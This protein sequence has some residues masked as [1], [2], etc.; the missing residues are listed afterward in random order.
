M[1]V[2][3]VK[4]RGI[5]RSMNTEQNAIDASKDAVESSKV[6]AEKIET[7]RLAQVDLNQDK[8]KE[9]M[10]EVLHDVFDEKVSSGRFID[11]SRIPL[12][13][14]S[15]M[16]LN[17]RVESIDDSITWVVRIVIGAVVLG[18]IALLIK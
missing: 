9:M 16:G 18:L 1:I 8:I 15:I 14:Q 6:A 5:I 17:K 12:I 7:A 10:I 2:G 4:R 11:V 13:C 3:K